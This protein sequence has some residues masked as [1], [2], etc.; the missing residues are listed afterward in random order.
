MARRLADLLLVEMLRSFLSSS[1]ADAVGWLRAMSD[2]RI[3][4]AVRCVHANPGKP[5]TLARLAKECRMSRSAF[6]AEFR[7]LVGETPLNYVTGWRMHLAAERLVKEERSISVLA[8]DLGYTSSI[9][10]TKA[11]RRWFGESPGQFRSRHRNS[12]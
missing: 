7:R 10:F 8:E 12:T 4:L 3:G 2:Q 5:W 6:A 1:P 9:S 11:F